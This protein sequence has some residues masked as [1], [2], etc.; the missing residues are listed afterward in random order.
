MNKDDIHHIV[1]TMIGNAFRTSKINKNNNMWFPHDTEKN[2]LTIKQK[3][4]R[5][6][7]RLFDDINNKKNLFILLTRHYYIKEPI[8]EEIMKTLLSFNSE[9]KILFISG[10]DHPYLYDEKY[11]NKIIFKYIFYDITRTFFTY[12][13]VFRPQIKD[14]I[15]SLFITNSNNTHSDDMMI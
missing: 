14:Y 2:V 9:N 4:K 3:Y 12:D 10:T 1:N 6:F 11:K 8:I 13:N 5:R 7:E 15:Q